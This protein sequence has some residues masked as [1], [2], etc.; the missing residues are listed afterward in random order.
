MKTRYPD[1]YFNE[2]TLNTLGYEQQQAGHLD[3]AIALF[4]LNVEMYPA[5]ANAYDSRAE[6]YMLKGDRRQAIQSYR[7]SLALD[8]KSTNAVRMLEKLDQDPRR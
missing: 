2:A 5:S 3:D 4:K 8:P 7:K 6:A 1:E